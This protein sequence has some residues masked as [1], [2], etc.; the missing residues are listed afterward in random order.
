MSLVFRLALAHHGSVS[1]ADSQGLPDVA[2][3]PAEIQ[4][5]PK[6]NVFLAN[7]DCLTW[8]TDEIYNDINII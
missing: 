8:R 1:F 2:D 3:Q 4:Q 6:L 7:T 5:V